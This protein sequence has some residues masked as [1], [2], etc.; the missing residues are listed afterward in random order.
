ME[1]IMT[2]ERRALQTD[3]I[4]KKLPTCKLF[5]KYGLTLVDTNDVIIASLMGELRNIVLGFFKGGLYSKKECEHCGTT[6]ASQFERAHQKGVARGDVARAALAR[7][8][9]DET[10]PIRQSDFIRA[11]VEEHSTV[12]LWIL[13]KP[14]HQR[15]DA[16]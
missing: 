12:P 7:V 8:R 6:T 5:N 1:H 10:Q 15:Y 14:C 2:A 11:F 16:K 13:C 4:Q 9:P 3:F